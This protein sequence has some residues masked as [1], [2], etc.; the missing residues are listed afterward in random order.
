MSTGG[1]AWVA[2]L[3]M[4][5]AIMMIIV[6]FMQ[7]LNGIVGRDYT[8]KFD[9]TA[10]GWIHLLLGIAV[11]AVGLCLLMG[12]TWARW[13]GLCIVALS[14]LANFAWIPY[15]PIWGFIVLAVD[16]A[17]IWALTVGSPQIIE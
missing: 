1:R 2:G 7:A 16:T 17:I 11:A 3:T 14:A 8:W 5:A 9:V 6:G 10:W 15:Y 12:Q 4:F 13:T